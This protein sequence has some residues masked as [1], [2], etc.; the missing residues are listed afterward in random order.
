[1]ALTAADQRLTDI[2]EKDLA[3]AALISA[4]TSRTVVDP[5]RNDEFIEVSPTANV[6]VATGPYQLPS[7][8]P[9][10]A[11]LPLS[12][13]FVAKRPLGPKSMSGKANRAIRLVA[14][15]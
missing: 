4:S 13:D 6:V 15:W 10:S 8:P 5:C 12:I 14:R 7:V 1:M 3:N 9:Y 11:M 2:V